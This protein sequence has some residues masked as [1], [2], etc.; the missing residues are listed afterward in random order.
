[1]YQV[2]WS[3]IA[4]VL[5]TLGTVLVPRESPVPTVAGLLPVSVCDA[6]FDA[7]CC[8][9]GLGWGPTQTNR[10]ILEIVGSGRR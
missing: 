3:A 9:A 2:Y 10:Y 4:S 8:V 7:V 1:M 5:A 6:A